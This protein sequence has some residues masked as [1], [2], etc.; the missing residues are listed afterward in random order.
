[1]AAAWDDA[2]G[3]HHVGV[4]EL[5]A[6]GGADATAPAPLRI[7]H[8]LQVPT[9]AHA[10]LP[11]PNATLVAV[12]RRPGAWMLRWRPGSPAATA[13][14]HWSEAD[15]SFNGHVQA[16]GQHALVCTETDAAD[17]AGLLVRRDAQTLAVLQEWP[18]GGTDPHAVL[19]LPEGGWLVANGGVPTRPESGR[20][21]GDRSTMDSSLVRLDA[22]GAPQGAWR[23]ADKRLSLRHLARHGNGLVGVA[24]Q[25]EHD[26]AEDRRDAPLIALWDGQHLRVGERAPLQGYAGDIVARPAGF[27][28]SATRAGRVAQFDLQGRWVAHHPLAKVCAVAPLDKLG[29]IAG[30]SEHAMAHGRDGIDNSVASFARAGGLRIDNHWACY[31]PPAPRPGNPKVAA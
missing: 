19:A 5:T 31:D 9:R 1:M 13:R 24:L 15:R 6:P 14:W 27:M 30:G 23:L 11:G 7:R 17:G 10:V 2:E 12:A 29:W 4:L 26:A 28:L 16:D 25:A 8:A 20:V 18:T 21:K 22:Q 3:C